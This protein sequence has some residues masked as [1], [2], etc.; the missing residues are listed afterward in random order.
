MTGDYTPIRHWNVLIRHRILPFLSNLP[1][2]HPQGFLIITQ[3]PTEMAARY[4]LSLER[5]I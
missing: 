5:R 2:P 3:I 1:P 4:R